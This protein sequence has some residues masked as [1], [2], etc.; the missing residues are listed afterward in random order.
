MRNITYQNKDDVSLLLDTE[1]GC[2]VKG[3]P[4][5]DYFQMPCIGSSRLMDMLVCPRYFWSGSPW[6][7]EDKRRPMEQTEAMEFGSAMHKALLEPDDFE[8]V[9]R[10]SPSKD[11]CLVTIADLMDYG[12]QQGV[13]LPKGTK[14][15]L[16]DI[17]LQRWPH[18]PVW[19]R[20]IAQFDE[21]CEAGNVRKV[22]PEKLDLMNSMADVLR[23]EKFTMG[24]TEL[25]LGQIFSKGEA[26]KTFFWRHKKTGL[27]L[28]CRVDWML[29]NIIFE[30]RTAVDASPRGFS[31]AARKRNY[32]HRAGFYW[33]IISEVTGVH[34][35]YYYMAQEK[36]SPHLVAMYEEVQDDLASGWAVC[37]WCLEQVAECLAKGDPYDPA[38][39]PTYNNNT[40]AALELPDFAFQPDG[41]E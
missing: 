28:M 35:Q 15:E 12:Q 19:S 34:P 40:V 10:T 5:N 41:M 37:E 8:N 21:D 3:L 31:L 23:S 2:S 11:G 4:E 7:P 25:P 18:A 17:V 33:K 6:C 36:R 22:T 38:N 16:E 24:D 20:I 29:A 27:D 30:Y 9:Y 1:G 26:E 13:K 32:Q 14:A 39:W